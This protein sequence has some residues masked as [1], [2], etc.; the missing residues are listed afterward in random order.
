M[1]EAALALR[2]EP[3]HFQLRGLQRRAAGA[4]PRRSQASTQVVSRG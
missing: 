4:G 2:I 1:V 3:A